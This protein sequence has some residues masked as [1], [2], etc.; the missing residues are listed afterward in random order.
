MRKTRHDG[1][2]IRTFGVTFH[3]PQT[4]EYPVEG[5]DQLIYAT[6]GV[7]TVHTD[8][9]TWALPAQ[10][11][12]WVPDGVRHRLQ[13][14][15]PVSLRS[16]Y[17]RARTAR[18]LPRRCCAVNVSPLLK[19]LIVACI[20]LGALSSRKPSHR[21]LAGVVLDQLTILPSVPLQLPQPKNLRARRM[22]GILATIPHTSLSDA[23]ER[24]GASLRTLERLFRAETE[25]PLGA[26]FRRL[27]LQ[28]AVERL[29][30]GATVSEAADSCGYNGPSA[31]VAMFRRELGV[32]PGRFLNPAQFP[33]EGAE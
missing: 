7:L 21:R 1:A 28:L 24:C 33:D 17:F 16:L 18:R 15:G 9:G 23:A 8:S 30:A 20:N 31:F 26:W 32:T 27:R 29:A 5:W 25:M 13:I 2:L 12:L 4:V 14:G 6:E 19:E 10:R 22:A 11:A 3:S